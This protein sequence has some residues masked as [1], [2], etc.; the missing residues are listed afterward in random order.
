MGTPVTYSASLISG[1]SLSTVVP[2]PQYR[3][4]VDGILSGSDSVLLVS[5][6]TDGQEVRLNIRSATSCLIGDGSTISEVLSA[7][8]PQNFIGGGYYCSGEQPNELRLLSSE[9]G[10]SYTLFRGTDSVSQFVGT[11]SALNFGRIGT[12]G[13]YRVRAV[14]GNG[15]AAQMGNV[16]VVDTFPGIYASIT[17]DTFIYLGGSTVLEIDA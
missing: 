8:S 12:P 10:V 2:N 3:W 5:G 14:G 16:I 1:A 7:P 17:N 6:L 9:A 15:C 11:G 4:F 13:S